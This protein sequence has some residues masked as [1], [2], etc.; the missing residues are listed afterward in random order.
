MKGLA[1]EPASSDA[2]GPERQ[3][4]VLLQMPPDHFRVGSNY[5]GGYGAGA[6]HGAR[7]RVAA[8]L[9]REHGLDLSSDWPVAVLGVD[10]YVMNVPPDRMGRREALV[11]A[12]GRDPRVAWAQ[13]MNVYRGQAHND[14]LFTVQPA[15]VEWHL[16]EL[17]EVATGRQ[18]RIAVVDSGIELAHPD[19][20]GQIELS[21]NFLADRPFA[22]E[23]HGTE[24]AGIIAARA[25]NGVGI[26]SAFV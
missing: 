11:Q 10:C 1:G 13:P 25:D 18:M 20:E 15:A 2:A 24:V 23:R 3:I 17:H 5:S 7:R 16:A 19:L 21:E 26:T 12:L 14:P 4:L 8:E 9:A 6:G 22:A